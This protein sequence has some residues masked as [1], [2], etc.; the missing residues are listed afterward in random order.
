MGRLRNQWHEYEGV[1]LLVT[2]HPAYLLRNP[3]DKSKAWEDLQ[4]VMKEFGK[5]PSGRG[6]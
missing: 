6:T 3:P 4:L 5:L 2:F 1:A